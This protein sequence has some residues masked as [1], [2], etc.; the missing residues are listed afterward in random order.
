MAEPAPQ[1]ETARVIV[2]RDEEATQAFRPDP[3][4]VRRMV[5]R[6]VQ[7]WTGKTNE[8]AA[9]Q[10]IVSKEDVVGIKVYSSPGPNSGTR[11][12]VAAAVVQGLIGAGLPPTNIIV[13]D[14]QIVD[15]RLAGFYE[16]VERYGVRVEGSLQAGYDPAV[17]YENAMMGSLVWGD[18]EFGTKND[19]AGRKSHVTTLL[20][21]RITKVISIPPLLNHNL[22]GVS[23]NLYSVAFGAV[24]NA[25]RFES[26]SDRLLV[27]LPEIY[28]MTAIA[29]KVVLC[30]VDAL[31]CQYEG[32]ERAL[33]HYSTALNELR[34]GTDPVAL[35]VL[36]LHD[37]SR[38]RQQNNAPRLRQP[39]D[40]YS[41][42]ALL[43]LGIADARLI[44]VETIH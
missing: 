37:V 32:G 2:V 7:A 28:N 30:I 8:A 15:L 22:A 3:N 39:L 18:L 16:L 1:S 36:S 35:D 19:G 44:R 21:K 10:A 17:F 43:E 24:D 42:A 41:N 12:A 34:F 6:G 29:D 4:T 14:R 5:V 38:F 9:W 23:G 33:L 25:A 11:V 13:W 20:T 27:P 31:I 26:S 40:I